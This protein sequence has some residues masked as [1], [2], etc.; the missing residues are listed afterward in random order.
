MATNTQGLLRGGT[1]VITAV[2]AG[3]ALVVDN[4]ACIG[5]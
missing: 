4:G 5:I 1:A 3:R 2:I